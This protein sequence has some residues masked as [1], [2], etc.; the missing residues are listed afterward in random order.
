MT[1]R[2]TEPPVWATYEYGD[3]A[4]IIS[5]EL[6]SVWAYLTNK[7][8]IIADCLLVTTLNPAD[9]DEVDLDVYAKH[10]APPPLTSEYASPLAHVNHPS[11]DMF[12]VLW[13]ENGDEVLVAL[14]DQVHAHLTIHDALGASKAIGQDGA[15]GHAWKEIDVAHINT[16]STAVSND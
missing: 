16:P 14:N 6:D 11:D 5:G 1:A 13:S 2:H 8:D 4:L 3:Y 10:D 9:A 7:D 12:R 15:Y